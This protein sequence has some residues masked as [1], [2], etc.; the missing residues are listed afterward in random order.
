[1][2]I[3]KQ[4]AKT[5]EKAPPGASLGAPREAPLAVKG[6]I[7]SVRVVSANMQQ[8]AKVE[9]D[10]KVFLPK[11]ERYEKKRTRMLVHNPLS[12]NAQPG[13]MVKIRECRPISKT[14]HFVIIEKV[15][16]GQSK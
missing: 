10:R 2:A 6:R 15:A 4:A 16:S 9:L 14:K 1:M 11:Y 3:K 12:V 5:S 13:D 8:T 7:M